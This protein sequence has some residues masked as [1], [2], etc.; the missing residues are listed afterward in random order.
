[1]T[2]LKLY[3]LYD[4]VQDRFI[5]IMECSLPADVAFVLGAVNPTSDGNHCK[6]IIV[7]GNL[8]T[9]GHVLGLKE[10]WKWAV[11]S[12]SVVMSEEFDFD[13]ENVE[14]RELLLGEKKCLL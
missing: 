12:K 8:E 1:M 3:A 10:W 13:V 7:S 9:H 11:D 4:K 14:I 6:E 2:S 5:A